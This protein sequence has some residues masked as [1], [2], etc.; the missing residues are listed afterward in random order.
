MWNE[1]NSK[2]QFVNAY[3]NKFQCG[4]E[5]S[6]VFIK[7][8]K[9]KENLFR[10]H[11]RSAWNIMVFDMYLLSQIRL[12]TQ[13]LFDLKLKSTLSNTGCVISR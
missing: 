8:E 2:N 6:R 7:K 10:L 13:L 9:E 5:F 4:Y 11:K 3:Y 1:F 12:W